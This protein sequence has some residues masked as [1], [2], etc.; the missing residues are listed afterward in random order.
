MDAYAETFVVLTMRQ[1]D[2]GLASVLSVKH[3]GRPSAEEGGLRTEVEVL[4]S[5]GMRKKIY[6][7]IL[8]RQRSRVCLYVLGD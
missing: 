6:W 2:A 4:L 7:R 1:Q 8:G 3:K 5:I